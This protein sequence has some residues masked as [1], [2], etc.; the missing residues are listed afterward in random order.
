MEGMTL[1]NL[2]STSNFLSAEQFEQI[3]ENHAKIVLSMAEFKFAMHMLDMKV[4]TLLLH[5][6]LKKE[7]EMRKEK[8]RKIIEKDVQLSEN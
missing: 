3:K 4:Q 8:Q 5:P 1:D 7:E 6:I 2:E